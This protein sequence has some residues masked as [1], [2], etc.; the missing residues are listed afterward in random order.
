MATGTN[1]YEGLAV[2][3]FGES[4]ITQQTAAN[5]ILTL[6]GADTMTGDFLVCE[7]SA[8]TELFVINSD[9]DIATITNFADDVTVEAGKH[10]ILNK[11]DQSTFSRVRLAI[12]NSAPSSAGLTK[13]EIWLAKSTDAAYRLAV[14]I[15]TAAGTVRYGK[16][17]VQSTLASTT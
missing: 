4:Q 12:L 6:T 15:S 3:L 17:I 1:T 16:R 9:G 5:D 8:G 2:P 7:N 13:G 11:T 10:V 14:C